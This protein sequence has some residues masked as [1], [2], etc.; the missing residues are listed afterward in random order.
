MDLHMPEMDGFETVLNIRK[1]N[2]GIK[3]PDIPIIALSAD[4][5]TETRDQVL[6]VGM[7]DFAT[8]PFK[9]AEFLLILD[10]WLNHEK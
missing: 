8:K 10:K 3:Q 7:D 6:A 2:V 5:F 1:G 9:P 4:A